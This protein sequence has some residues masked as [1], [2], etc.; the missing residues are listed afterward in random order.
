M[1]R[2][3]RPASVRTPSDQRVLGGMV[4]SEASSIS[5]YFGPRWLSVGG[6]KTKWGTIGEV[7]PP[8]HV[9]AV[10]GRDCVAMRGADSRHP[11]D[12]T[13]VFGP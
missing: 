13:E 8:G 10:R 3:A 4:A 7:N 6:W 2:T 11:D 12:V 1:T 9:S 5:R